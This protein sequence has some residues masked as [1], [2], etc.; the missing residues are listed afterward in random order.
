MDCRTLVKMNS[1]LLRTSILMF[2]NNCADD[3]TGAVKDIRDT[4]QYAQ[5]L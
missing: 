5:V 3:L 2:F 1:D 4:G